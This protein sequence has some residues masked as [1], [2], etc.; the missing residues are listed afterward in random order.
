M[1]NK[2]YLLSYLIKH[3]AGRFSCFRP[4]DELSLES[5]NVQGNHRKVM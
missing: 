3:L 2:S 1:Q 5:G 4:C